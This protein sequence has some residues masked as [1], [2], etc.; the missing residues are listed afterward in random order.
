MPRGCGLDFNGWVGT[1]GL[2]LGKEYVLLKIKITLPRL[3]IVL[4]TP[5]FFH[6][7]LDKCSLIHL[8]TTFYLCYNVWAMSTLWDMGLRW[9]NLLILIYILDMSTDRRSLT[10]YRFRERSAEDSGK[11]AKSSRTTWANTVW[12]LCE[13]LLVMLPYILCCFPADEGDSYD[14][15]FEYFDTWQILFACA[16]GGEETNFKCFLLN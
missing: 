1:T 3:C 5:D 13:W 12:N 16:L 7:F 6:R 11:S 8:I 14:I 4:L 2:E 15:N 9:L 10:M